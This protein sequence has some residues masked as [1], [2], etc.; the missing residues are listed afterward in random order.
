MKA[1][2]ITEY[3][4]SWDGKAARHLLTAL[5]VDHVAMSLIPGRADRAPVCTPARQAL[6]ASEKAAKVI[7]SSLETHQKRR[8]GLVLISGK[9]T[10]EAFGVSADYFD[11][12]AVAGIYTL[13][14]IPHPYSAPW[15]DKPSNRKKARKAMRAVVS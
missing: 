1:L 4:V 5:D 13:M 9:K 14:L 3:E 7:L 11:T 6:D 12:I 2:V 10:A 15:W 8:Y